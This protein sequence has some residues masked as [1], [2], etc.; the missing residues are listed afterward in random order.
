MVNA[1]GKTPV[2]NVGPSTK[3]RE[4]RC[5]VFRTASGRAGRDDWPGCPFVQERAIQRLAHCPKRRPSP[6]CRWDTPEGVKY[7]PFHSP[8]HFPR[9]VLILTASKAYIDRG[10]HLSIPLG[11]QFHQESVP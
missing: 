1:R 10:M 5:Q 2:R 8:T 11:H 3:R 9:S 7:A 6:R 4:N